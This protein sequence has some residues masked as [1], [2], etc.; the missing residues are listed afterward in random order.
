MGLTNKDQVMAPWSGCY[1]DEK[2]DTTDYD[3]VGRGFM[4]LGTAG[5]VRVTTFDGETKTF[6]SVPSGVLVPLLIKRLHNSGTAAT[7]IVVGY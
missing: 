6:T 5:A 3:N 4:V 7:N 2:S 1:F